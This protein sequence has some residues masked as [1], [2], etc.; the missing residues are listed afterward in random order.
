MRGKVARAI[1]KQLE[2]SDKVNLDLRSNKYKKVPVL[3]LV[4]PVT[5]EKTVRHTWVNVGKS[6]YRR[7]KKELLLNRSIRG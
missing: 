7:I 2:T 5:G 4:N 1:R 6:V 3:E